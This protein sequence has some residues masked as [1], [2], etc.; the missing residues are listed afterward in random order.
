M[1]ASLAVASTPKA[2]PL[3]RFEDFPVREVYRGKPAAPKLKSRLA[4][5][6]R[7]VIRKGASEGPN[8]AG[9]YTVVIWGCGI[10]C[11]QFAIVDAST[12]ETYDPP[13]EG[14]T[15]HDGAGFLKDTGLHFRLDSSL[16]VAEGCPEE[17]DCAARYYRWNGNRLVLIR[18]EV[19]ER[20]PEPEPEP[21]AITVRP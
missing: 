2:K 16:F 19:A 17:K 13:F 5:A 6:F 3:P 9:H 12:G 18:T 20:H 7:T 21:A 1:V 15:W 8:F 4:R 11:A 10:S 14:I